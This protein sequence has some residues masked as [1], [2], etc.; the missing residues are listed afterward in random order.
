MNPINHAISLSLG[1]R[2][3]PSNLANPHL[4]DGYMIKPN[5]KSEDDIE[6][7]PNFIESRDA[8]ALFEHKVEKDER[9]LEYVLAI[10]DIYSMRR[11]SFDFATAS[12]T[13]RCR[14]Y[15]RVYGISPADGK[16]AE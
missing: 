4:F 1:Y 16:E 15:C 10:N 7:E 2:D 9:Q 12:P 8:C 6:K 3:I 11:G 5:A 14:A 13:I